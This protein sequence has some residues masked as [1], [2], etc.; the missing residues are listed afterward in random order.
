[1]DEPIKVNE[2]TMEVSARD[3]HEALGIHQRFSA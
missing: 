1:M 3:V 2:E